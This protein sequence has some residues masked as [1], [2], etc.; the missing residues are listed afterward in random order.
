MSQKILIIGG[1]G[2]LGEPVSRQLQ[3]C[4]FG[5]RIFT[6]SPDKARVRFPAPFE[7]ARG[8]VEDLRSL[9]IAMEG[10]SGVHI[11]L[12][13]L[14]DPDLERRG[15][16][17]IACAAVKAG[18]QRITYLSGA[19]VCEE[20]AWFADTRARLQAEAAICASGVP[21]TVFRAHFFMNTLRNFVRGRLL[22]QIGKH[23]HPYHWVDSADYACMVARA[24]DTPQSVDKIL[25]VCGPQ[26]FTMR[27]ALQVL[28]RTAYPD[29][30]IVYLPLW[31]A[32]WFAVL[33]KRPQ[34]QSTIPFFAYCEKVKVILSGSPEEANHLLGAPTTTL[35]AWARRELG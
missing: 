35:E 27:E 11:N 31:A 5:V 34:L 12:H 33:G 2:M 21:Y 7:I 14:F 16:E 9:E 32:R 29:H 22:L 30:R 25:F 19:S 1:T 23:P 15:A 24:Y 17:A 4:G 28:K 3:S 8:D 10:C 26:A 6:R 13:G 20:N 18:L